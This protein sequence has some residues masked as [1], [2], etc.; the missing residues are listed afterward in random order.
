VV[1]RQTFGTLGAGAFGQ[2]QCA[3]A[4]CGPRSRQTEILILWK[5]SDGF[6]AETSKRPQRSRLLG[7]LAIRLKSSLSQARRARS[8]PLCRSTAAPARSAADR[9]EM[10]PVG[11]T[12]FA[13]SPSARDSERSSARQGL[14]EGTDKTADRCRATQASPRSLVATCSRGPNADHPS[15]KSLSAILSMATS[16]GMSAAPRRYL[17]G[18]VPDKC[19]RTS[20]TASERF[21]LMY[22]TR[23]PFEFH[24]PP[25]AASALAIVRG[26]GTPAQ[27]ECPHQPRTPNSIRVRTSPASWKPSSVAVA[28]SG[29][30]PLREGFGVCSQPKA[31]CWLAKTSPA[32]TDKVMNRPGGTVSNSRFDGVVATLRTS[33]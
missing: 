18:S 10:S 26:V 3:P 19:T 27:S 29:V 4:M 25:G 20:S 7:P 8:G 12:R 1:R 9:T 15:G 21:S 28:S 5:S 17:S 30:R 14:P 13:Q 6:G 22:R 2:G 11:Q 16:S 24:R 33:S 31:F 32:R 23:T